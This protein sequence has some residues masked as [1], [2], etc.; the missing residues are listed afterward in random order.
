MNLGELSDTD[1]RAQEYEALRVGSRTWTNR[2]LPGL[3]AQA[4]TAAVAT[5]TD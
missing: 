3:Q 1:A 4:V 5:G 2:A